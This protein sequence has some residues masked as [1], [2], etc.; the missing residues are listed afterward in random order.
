MLLFSLFALCINYTTAN[1]SCR[2]LLNNKIIYKGE[3]DQE[4]AVASV[5]MD[6]FKKTD[7]LK[8]VYSSE[9]AGK[10]W[11]RT[12]YIN[13][14]NDENLRTL[15]LSKQSGSVSVKASV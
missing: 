3:V 15:E 14:P 10:G 11:N 1:D 8:I 12:F 13:G 6:Q 9:N 4:N 7:C 2:I 5:K